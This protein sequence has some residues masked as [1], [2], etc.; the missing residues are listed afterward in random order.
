[1]SEYMKGVFLF[2]I[3]IGAL[4]LVAYRGG[5]KNGE[6][7]AF[8][9][10]LALTVLSPVE[11]VIGEIG[12]DF[13]DTLPDYGYSDGSKEYESV[14]RE[15]MEKSIKEALAREFSVD[16]GL[17][18]VSLSDFSFS[19]MKA[20]RVRVTLSLGAGRLEPSKVKSFVEGL[21]V[22]ECEVIYEIG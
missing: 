8:A 13:S 12:K 18:T 7:I 4:E 1:M 20:E 16:E 2:S 11:S 3:I 19:E 17:V 21:S 10:L 9:L 15:A 5:E 6:K 22:G 14:A